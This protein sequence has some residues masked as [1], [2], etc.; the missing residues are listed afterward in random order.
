MKEKMN[1]DTKDSNHY[2]KEAY[3][4]EAK[5]PRKGIKADDEDEYNAKGSMDW[6]KS[7]SP[8]G[9]YRSQSHA[10]EGRGNRG[11][12]QADGGPIK[13]WDVPVKPHGQYAAQ[14]HWGKGS[15]E[16]GSLGFKL[17]GEAT[18]YLGHMKQE[19]YL[20]MGHND[21]PSWGTIGESD[22]E[23]EQAQMKMQKDV[24]VNQKKPASDE[25]G[26]RAAAQ[27]SMREAFNYGEDD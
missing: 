16:S 2:P 13:D 11:P 18:G 5:A 26:S 21:G 20:R 3:E 4:K 14:Q 27:K 19:K 24:N 17:E 23:V 25:G 1:K 6:N 10:P 15:A 9:A 7:V 8:Y 22:K 12:S